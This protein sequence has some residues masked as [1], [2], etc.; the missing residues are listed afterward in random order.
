MNSP[1][2]LAEK[3]NKKMSHSPFLLR[4]EEDGSF[5]TYVNPDYKFDM[6]K[7]L[8]H[9][10]GYSVVDAGFMAITEEEALRQTINN[11]TTDAWNEFYDVSMTAMEQKMDPE[12]LVAYLEAWLRITNNRPKE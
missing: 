8:I 3:T 4:E 11:A 12:Y 10:C 1:S 7:Y 2:L 5:V 6:R 9:F